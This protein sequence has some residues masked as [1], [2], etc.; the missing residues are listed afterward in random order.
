MRPAASALSASVSNSITENFSASAAA[1]T[2]SW[3]SARNQEAWV[4]AGPL[5]V[6]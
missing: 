4:N 5:G 6:P 2:A 3:S 1:L